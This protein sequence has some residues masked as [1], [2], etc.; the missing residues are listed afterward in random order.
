MYQ[1]EFLAQAV[2][3]LQRLDQS[4]AQRIASKLRFV[5]GPHRFVYDC[6]GR[7]TAG[8]A[9]PTRMKPP[10]TAKTPSHKNGKFG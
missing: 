7:I 2:N 10:D 6:G 1:V 5:G 4:V 8:S 9:D 3:D